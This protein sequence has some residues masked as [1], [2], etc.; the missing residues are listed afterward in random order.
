M[1]GPPQQNPYQ[2]PVPAQGAPAGYGAAHDGK[3]KWFGF[4]TI[5][6]MVMGAMG[7]LAGMWAPVNLF[8]AKGSPMWGMP[9]GAGMPPGMADFQEKIMAAAMPEL[10]AGIAVI[11]LVTGAMILYAAIQLTKLRPGAREKFRSS[12][13]ALAIYE[14]VALV[15]GLVIQAR[16]YSIMEGLFGEIM[17]Q[18][19]GRPPP[20]GFENTV[21]AAMQV[22][23]VVGL[24]A[25]LVWGG[26]KIFFALWVRA[27]ANRP[28]VVKYAGA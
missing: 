27:Y 25:G 11:N 8:V 2:P 6:S 15:V 16:I 3:P 10:T 22:A 26:C 7:V 1:Q 17:R 19:G 4:V 24:I 14:A 23:M 9:S 12:A 28:E 13:L 21:G 18:S 20:P 5:A